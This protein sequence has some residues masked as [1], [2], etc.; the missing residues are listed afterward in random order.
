MIPNF[1]LLL[2]YVVVKPC[3]VLYDIEDEQEM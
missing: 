3:V 2:S 1:S